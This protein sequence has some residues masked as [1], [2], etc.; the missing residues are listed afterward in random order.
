[1][2]GP[3]PFDKTATATNSHLSA[4]IRWVDLT[5]AMVMVHSG[6]PASRLR[7]R[8]VVSDLLDRWRGNRQ[9]TWTPTV[10]DIDRLVESVTQW[11]AQRVPLFW[12]SDVS[13][14]STP[15]ATDEPRGE[16]S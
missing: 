4:A 11:Q 2:A 9:P 8:Q 5:V 13:T 10:G 7:R 16:A 3:E 12:F 15:Q 14:A 1:M 6:E